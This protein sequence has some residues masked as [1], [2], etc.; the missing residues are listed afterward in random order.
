MNMKNIKNKKEENTHSGTSSSIGRGV[1]ETASF[2]CGAMVMVVEMAGSRL[3]APWMGSSLIVWTSLIGIILACL[4]VGYW[5][6]GKLAD[7]TPKTA[8]LSIIILAA[9]VSVAILGISANPVLLFISDSIS[10]LYL[11]SVVAAII[12]FSIPSI[13]LGMVSPM[14]VRIAL[15]SSSHIGATVGR[16]S[17]LSCIGSILGTFLGG[18]VLI[19]LF[20]T[21]TILMLTAAILAV[22]SGIVWL[23]SVKAKKA[24]T[25]VGTTILVITFI[26]LGT[27]IE[28]N[29]MPMATDGIHIETTYNHIRIYEGIRRGEYKRMRILQTDP[30]G[31]QSAMYVD[32]PN[33]LVFDY[34]KFYD[35]AFY[36]RPEIKNVLMLG[37]GGYTIPKYLSAFFPQVAVDVVELDPGMTSAAEKY[38]GFVK[39]DNTR[40][41]HEDAR[42]FINRVSK[43]QDKYDAVFWDTFTSEYNIPF[44]LT[45]VE[46]A[47][48]VYDML[49]DD[50]ITIMNIISAADGKSGG[51]FKGIYASFSEVFPHIKIF[52][53]TYPNDVIS[54][55]NV[56]LVASKS[57]LSN[58]GTEDVKISR[59]L[60]HE[61]TKP[62]TRD[63]KAFTDSFAPVEY[64]ALMMR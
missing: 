60:P 27:W 50:G 1:L 19:S 42:T 5:L 39:N 38:F 62:I 43:T 7:I 22:T 9:A 56:V 6:G 21:G 31:S 4:S 47:R 57:E 24:K 10:N 12:L 41:F 54:R 64:Y 18:F 26:A 58:E 25:P 32:S 40:V 59:L 15:D 14:I 63:I 61:L 55:Q 46:S 29:G 48:R 2:V 52:L 49:P 20:S 35:L 16:F 37:G 34:T 44:H 53:A 8:S 51:V 33:E 11:S 17:A 45:T 3:L 28:I 36:Y 23:Q 13:L 30:I